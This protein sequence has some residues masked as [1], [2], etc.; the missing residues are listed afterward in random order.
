MPVLDASVLVEYVCG[1][2]RGAQVRERILASGTLWTP[3]LADAEV[4]HVLRRAV[5]AGELTAARAGKALDV[6]ARMPLRRVVHRPLLARAWALRENV[7]FYDALYV[8]LAERLQLPL[9]TLDR[10]IA[11]APGLRT[12]VEVIAADA[13]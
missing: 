9:I 13:P 12:A 7:S 11:A 8:A 4:G 2:E 5:R 6:L 3:H 1:G 10:R